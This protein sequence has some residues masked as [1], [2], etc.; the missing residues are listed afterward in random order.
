MKQT[1]NDVILDV[2][3]IIMTKGLE[4]SWLTIDKWIQTLALLNLQPSCLRENNKCSRVLCLSLN[5]LVENENYNT[6]I[7]VYVIAFI[8]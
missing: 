2:L 3:L 1:N 6:K 4:L 8:I 7:I 5:Q